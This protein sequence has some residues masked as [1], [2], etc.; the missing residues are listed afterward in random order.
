MLNTRLSAFALIELMVSIVVLS[1]LLG[2][3]A[4]SFSI[5]LQNL[6]IRNAA[7]SIQSGLQR[8]RAEAVGRNTNIEFVLG[9]N[10]SWVVRLAG[11]ANIDTRASSEGSKNVTVAVFPAGATTVTFNSFGGLLAV[12]TDGSLPFTRVD[13]DSSVLAPRDSQDLRVTIGVG[14]N[15]R[16]CDPNAPASSLQAC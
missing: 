8:A 9:T 2:L 4:P 5:W 1:I 6:Q 7:S 15:V 14:G 10:S 13:L 11:G 3:A 12:N 16:M